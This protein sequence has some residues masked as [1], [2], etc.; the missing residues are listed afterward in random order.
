MNTFI[1]R[2]N[3]AYAGNI[4]PH[5]QALVAAGLFTEAQLI[6]LKAVTQTI[7]LIPLG[8]PDPWH[9]YFTTDLRVDRPINLGKVRE[10]MSIVPFFDAFNLFNYAPPGLYSTLTGRYGALN[11]DYA[12]AGPGANAS[13][14]DAT[15]T[16]KAD[17]RR[18]QFGFRFNF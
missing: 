4:T 18:V 8:N 10:G 16:R 2:F 13:D 7:P 11:F 12:N 1:Q 15:R 14:L 9:N 6:Q 17:T 3:S 5:G